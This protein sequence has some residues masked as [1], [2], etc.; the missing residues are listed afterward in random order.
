MRKMR[1]LAT[2]GVAAGAFTLSACGS[3]APE[4]R[5]ADAFGTMGEVDAITATVSV[6][7]ISGVKPLFEEEGDLA[8]QKVEELVPELKLRWAAKSTDGTPVTGTTDGQWTG[9]DWR[10]T[11][12]HSDTA[13]FDTVYAGEKVSSRVAVEEILELL[14]QGEQFAGLQQMG[15]SYPTNDQWLDA[16]MNG[17][18]VGLDDKLNKSFTEYLEEAAAEAETP[19]EEEVAALDE[20]KKLV[21]L[22]STYE[23][24]G[25]NM[26]MEIPV[27]TVLEKG[28]EHVEVLME[29]ED[30][31]GL[32]ELQKNLNDSTFPVKYT[33]D[34]ERISRVVV[35]PFEVFDLFDKPL[36]DMDE[37]TFA[38]L[39]EASLPVVVD[40]NYGDPD[41]SVPSE[42]PLVT[43][44]DVD[45]LGGMMFMG[46][47]PDLMDDLEPV[48]TD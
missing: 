24:D 38:N 17:E 1:L 25:D 28:R 48:E 10:V 11:V 7:D 47:N 40:F 32:D 35:D 33:F 30:T 36:N 31:E 16:L 27:K 46:L 18:W 5:L 12:L 3:P 14:D 21:V 41:F 15:E 44:E 42:M 9:S 34:D 26:T 23:V 19:S 13:L 4:E 39:K 45:S 6:P 37:E 8:T 2:A 29:D 43:E 20:L 22:E